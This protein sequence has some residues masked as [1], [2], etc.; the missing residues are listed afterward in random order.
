MK[1]SYLDI[2][3]RLVRAALLSFMIYPVAENGS[4]LQIAVMTLSLSLA[5]TATVFASIYFKSNKT[6]LKKR[7]FKDWRN[8]FDY[9]TI[10][11]AGIIVNLAVG[12]IRIAIYYSVL[13]LFMLI[14]F[15]IPSKK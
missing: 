15:L 1:T 2:S 10:F 12:N 5:V 7:P 9:M 4:W 14:A 3:E 13:V 11:A 6:S 8:N